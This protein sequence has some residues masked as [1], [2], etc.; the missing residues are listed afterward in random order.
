MALEV[1]NTRTCFIK[2]YLFEPSQICF[3]A[4]KK[5]FGHLPNIQLVQFAISN[6]NDIAQLYYSWEG[7]SGASLSG[8]LM[9]GQGFSQEKVE[10]EQVNLIKLDDFCQENKIEKIDFLKLD[11]EGYELSALEGISDMLSRKKVGFIQVE[12]GAASLATKCMLFNIWTMLD[13]SYNFYLILK[14]GVTQIVY[15]PDLECFFGASNFLLEL[16]RSPA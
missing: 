13:S 4:L 16:K 15:K 5:E 9:I 7:S 14:H 3:D 8:E 10:S 6:I 2:L 1:F 12:I 11:I